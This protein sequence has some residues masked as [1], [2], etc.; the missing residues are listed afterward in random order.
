[1]CVVGLCSVHSS[2]A[3]LVDYGILDFQW[4]TLL[5]AGMGIILA[6]QII[7]S[8]PCACTWHWQGV[9]PHYVVVC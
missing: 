6:T 4:K 7:E 8:S 2:F 5:L 9:K 1:M 3:V